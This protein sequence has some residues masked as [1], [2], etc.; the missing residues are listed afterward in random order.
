MGRN[1]H[2]IETTDMAIRQ[3]AGAE[4]DLGRM[5]DPALLVPGDASGCGTVMR[6]ATVANFHEHEDILF[7]HNQVDLA[8]AAGKTM[9]YQAQAM[10]LEKSRCS[11]LDDRAEGPL[12][13]RL[14]LVHGLT[15]L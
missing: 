7:P 6:A 3:S 4:K 15:S 11:L 2:H 5:D 14:W 1:A 12:L 13:V 9:A 10:L 8:C